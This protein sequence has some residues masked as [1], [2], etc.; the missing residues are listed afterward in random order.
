MAP[1]TPLRYP[2]KYFADR[3]DPLLAGVGVFVLH[4]VVSLVVV[5]I[6]LNL[7]FAQIDDR[8]PSLDREI[9]SVMGVTVIALI[10]VGVIA[11]LL[12]A[13]IM[14]YLS[15]GSSTDGTFS[16]ALA[17]AGWAY[18]PEVIMIPISFLY[19]YR[20]ISEL[21]FSG[22]DPDRLAREIEAAEAG[23][24]MQLVPFL[25]LLIVT[26]WSV[27]ILAKGVSETHDVPLDAAAFPAALVGIGSIVLTL[28]G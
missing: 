21:S 17:V 11:W 13:A 1:L 26:A 12:V 4:L 14:H 22:S 5:N 15:G 28:L 20:Y 3:A 2:G 18:A 19:M 7:L 24:E 25:V 6:T 8:P 27:Y 9:S 16:D 10:V 23:L